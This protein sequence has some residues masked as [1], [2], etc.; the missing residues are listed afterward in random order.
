M[1]ITDYINFESEID[2]DRLFDVEQRI[3]LL[4]REKWPELDTTPSSPFGNLVLTPIARVITLFEQSADCILGDLNLE[5]ALNSIVCDCSFVESFLKG[6]GLT[7]LTEINTTATI[8]LTFNSNQIYNFDQS[9]PLLFNNEFVFNFIAGKSNPTIQIKKWSSTG[10]DSSKTSI[11]TTKLAELKTDRNNNI[12][13]LS[14]AELYYDNQ[15]TQPNQ[16]FVD[17]PIYG[18]ATASITAGTDAALDENM[19]NITNIISAQIIEDV[20][21]LTLPTTIA[22]LAKLCQSIQPSSN[23]TTRAG[24]SSYVFNK[25]PKT[26]GVSGVISGDDEMKR[27]TVESPFETVSPYLDIYVKGSRD[28]YTCTEIIP[29][30]HFLRLEQSTVQV[31]SP[32]WHFQHIPIQFT[33]I[34][35]MDGTEELESADETQITT[36]ALMNNIQTDTVKDLNLT[37]NECYFLLP[38][39]PIQVSDTSTSPQGKYYLKV[40][41]L[42]DPLMEAVQKTIESPACCPVINTLTRPFYPFIFKSF[43]ISYRKETGK[44]FD[45]QAAVDDIYNFINSLTYP[46]IYDDAYISDIMISNGASG[47]DNISADI[48]VSADAAEQYVNNPTKATT[49]LKCLYSKSIS[50]QS[51]DIS[52]I[53]SSEPIKAL[54]GLGNRNVQYILKRENIN[55]IEKA[56]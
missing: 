22:E 46:L 11:N 6:L 23:L 28:L 19:P 10:V 21:P 54:F 7:S 41:Y 2:S 56:I 36:T 39:H 31:V 35:C 42:Y 27:N 55:L 52:A 33:G 17:I 30:D 50:S 15:S 8:R 26:I 20:E 3:R 32:W 29:S 24:V 16:F 44:F 45:R 37:E 49:V 9:Y 38:L 14:A 43:T 48:S 13:Q 40:S 47:V 1:D 18:P 51:G 12:Y 5:N 34:T 25:F 53:P 4:M